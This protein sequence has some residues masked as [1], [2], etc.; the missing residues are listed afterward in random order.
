MADGR[1]RHQ[2]K[3][4]NHERMRGNGPCNERWMQQQMGGG[5]V[6]RGDTTMALQEAMAQ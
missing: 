2:E 3:Q 6:R 5:S 1:W 4:H